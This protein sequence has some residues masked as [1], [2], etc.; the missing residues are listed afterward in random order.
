MRRAQQ[1]LAIWMNGIP[2]GYW[3]K[4][5]GEDRLQYSLEWTEDPQGRPL[6]LS[7]PFTPGNQVH[8]TSLKIV[9]T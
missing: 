9:I 4:Q 6:S 2:V 5:K 8:R 1:R 3:V 7:L